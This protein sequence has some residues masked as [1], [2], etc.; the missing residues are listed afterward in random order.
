MG[1]R[2]LNMTQ[3]M[4]SCQIIEI[5]KAVANILELVARDQQITLKLMEDQLHINWQT[6]Y[7]ILYEDLGKTN[8]NI[9]IKFVHRVS[10]ISS[11]C[12]VGEPLPGKL[13]HGQ[14]QPYK[15]FM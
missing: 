9:C 15:L 8:K 2:T 1:M 7:Q 6:E 12:Q 10:Q 3:R 4:H 13:Q 14:Y 11:F 5:W